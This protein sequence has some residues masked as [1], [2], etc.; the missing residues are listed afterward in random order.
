M[1]KHTDPYQVSQ[2]FSNEKVILY[3]IPKYQREYTWGPKEWNLLFNDIIENENGY[4]LGSIICVDK[5]KSAMNDVEL[6]VIDGQQRITSLS[7]LLVALYDKLSKYK[8]KFDDDQFTDLNNIKREL[9]IKR[10]NE[11][12]ARLTPQVQGNNRSDYF[13][14]LCEKGLL[15]NKEKKSFAGLRK[16]YKGFYH[17]SN[18]I[19]KHIEEILE[20]V[21]EEEL[22]NEKIKALFDLTRKFNSAILVS[23]EVETN[24]DAYMLFESLNNRGIPLSAIDLIKNL[25]I[26]ISDQD[27]KAKE[28]HAK[29]EK[30]INNYLTDDYSVQERFFRQFYNAYREELNKPF[31]TGGK[32]KYA[33]GY[34]ATRTTLLDIY[35]K[36][37]KNGYEEFLDRL[38]YEAKNYAILINNVDEDTKNEVLHDSLLNLERIQ[39]A[40]AYILLLYLMSN[41]ESLE[42]NDKI[43]KEIIDFLVKFFVRRNITDY[44]NT[45]NLTKIFM[46][47]VSLISDK[48]GEEIYES[49]KTFLINNSSSDEEF[50]KKLNGGLYIDNPEA[51]RFLLC[52]YENRF[53]TSERYTDLWKRDNSNKYVWTIEHIFP[54]GNNIPDSWVNMIAD[55]NREL[56]NE[57]L[58]KYV[59]TL[60][61]L[62]ITGYNQTL[63]NLSFIEKKDRKKDGKFVGYRNGLTLNEDVVSEEEWKI[64]NIN[65]RTRKLVNFFVEEFKL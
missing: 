37:L 25:L 47:A 8:S 13:S 54:E 3:K 14:L 18:M 1:I 38:L 46:D 30:I 21:P 36:L 27:G 35:E 34:L 9:V 50:E 22:E 15:V 44:P 28:C 33:L 26:S 7:L 32:T 64:D 42:L 24:K 52:Y 58:N 31:P 29:W 49:I 62:T 63:S 61:N 23:I 10:D 57:Y 4:F 20:E 16:M 12:Y 40:P 59:H 17:F 45:R 48:K 6:E 51:T 19:D 11:M 41:K 55:G 56:A 60:G 43:I 2:I 5:S 65:N 39:G 53:M